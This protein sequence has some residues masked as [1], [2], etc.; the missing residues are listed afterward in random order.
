MS[1]TPP[2]GHWVESLLSH[3]CGEASASWFSKFMEQFATAGLVAAAT[4]PTG[5]GLLVPA[6]LALLFGVSVWRGSGEDRDRAHQALHLVERL[7]NT[8]RDTEAARTLIAG[9]VNRGE[10][11]AKQPL[12]FAWHFK[13]QL[14]RRG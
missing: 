6:G 2:A 1:R 4:L 11:W 13:V 7:S 5:M 10:V 8:G 12:H 3:F 9:V 14:V